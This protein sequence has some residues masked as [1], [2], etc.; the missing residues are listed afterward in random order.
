MSITS[1]GIKKHEAIN[2]CLSVYVHYSSEAPRE[3]EKKKRKLTGNDST[4]N[5]TSIFGMVSHNVPTIPEM[6]HVRQ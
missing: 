2:E 4:P 5:T 3:K 1:N 6:K